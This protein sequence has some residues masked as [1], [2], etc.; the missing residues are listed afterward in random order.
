MW[1]NEQKPNTKSYQADKLAK[2]SDIP[3]GNRNLDAKIR[4]VNDERC[5]SY[6]H[7]QY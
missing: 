7:K 6:I 2:G 4:Q 1:P 5:M 3:K